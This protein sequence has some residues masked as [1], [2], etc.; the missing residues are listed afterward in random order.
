TATEYV[1]EVAGIDELH[2]MLAR[3]DYVCLHTPLTED[4]RDMLGPDE[5]AAMK[6]GAYFLNGARGGIVDEDALLQALQSGHLNGAYS[7]VFATEP[8]PADSPL[9]DAPNL[10]ISPHVSDS[11]ANWEVRYVDFFAINLQR[12][13]D[14]QKLLNIVDGSLGY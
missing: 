11:I 14:G 8:L 9:W 6:P 7:D 12:W 5:F 1:D 10:I 4:T 2:T 13:L 3:A